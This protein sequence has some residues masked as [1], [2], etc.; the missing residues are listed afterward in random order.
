MH[1]GKLNKGYLSTRVCLSENL[2]P[3]MLMSP[4]PDLDSLAEELKRV[5]LQCYVWLNALKTPFRPLNVVFYG[6]K[7]RRDYNVAPKWFSGNQ[8]S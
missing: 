4:P 2:R 1:T 3:K 8:L 5:H 6:W 7:V